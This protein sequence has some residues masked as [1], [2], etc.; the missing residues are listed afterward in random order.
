HL[1]RERIPGVSVGLFG[2][3]LH[4]VTDDPAHGGDLVAGIVKQEGIELLGIRQIEPSLED[5]FVSVLNDNAEGKPGG[6]A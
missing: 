2:D 1:L 6:H 4:L 3:R 5:V